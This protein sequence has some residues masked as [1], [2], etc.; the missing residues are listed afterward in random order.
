MSV[1]VLLSDSTSLAS[2][3][4]LPGPPA[5]PSSSCPPIFSP[6]LCS[7]PS[8]LA[9]TPT[10]QHWTIPRAL[11]HRVWPLSC[12][13]VS[14]PSAATSA[15]AGSGALGPTCRNSPENRAK[16]QT[17]TSGEKQRDRGSRGSPQAK[18]PRPQDAWVP[19]ALPRQHIHVKVALG[20]KPKSE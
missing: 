10:L 5:L 11:K 2:S 15:G 9:S 14:G 3:Q 16:L 1:H 7:A 19:E 13:G 6:N 12:R 18:P 17:P 8:T 4:S 20:Q